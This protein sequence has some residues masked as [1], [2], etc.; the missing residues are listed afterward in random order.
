MAAYTGSLAAILG[1]YYVIPSIAYMTLSLAKPR[2]FNEYTFVSFQYQ[3]IRL[4]SDVTVKNKVEE[5]RTLTRPVLW[6]GV[7]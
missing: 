6:F 1:Y 7:L 2:T 5:N 4:Y 3:G